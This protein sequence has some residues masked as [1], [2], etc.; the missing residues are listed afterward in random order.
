MNNM[1]ALYVVA[2]PIGNLEDI[3]LRAL[4]I[5]GQVKLVAAEDTRKTRHLLKTYGIS[6]RL[7]SYHEHNKLTK[8]GYL[9]EQ[10]QDGDVALVSEAGMPGL[11]DPGYELIAA[12]IQQGIPVIPVPGPSSI[13]TALAVSGLPTDRFLYLG[14]LPRKKGQRRNLLESQADQQATLIALEA[15]H[16]LQ[17]SLGDLIE[18]LGERQVAVCR[19]LTKMYEEIFRGTLSQAR[20]HFREPRGEFTLVIEGNRQQRPLAEEDIKAE[21]KRLRRRGASGKEAVAQVA[22]ESGLSKREVYRL[23][24]RIRA[25]SSD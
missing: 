17:Q 21:L 24:L 12:A 4:R 2:T 14:F 1:S 13:I 22:T 5:L 10:M 20:Q 19:E 8:L 7:T 23:W 18:V 15:P 11:S 25:E 3:T 6:T 16:R 9:L